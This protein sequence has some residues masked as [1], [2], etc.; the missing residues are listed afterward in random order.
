MLRHLGA[1]YYDSLH[2]R[3]TRVDVA[4]A[5]GTV[6][7]HLT[8]KGHRHPAGSAPRTGHH[9]PHRQPGRWKRRVQDVMTTSVVTIDRATPYKEIALLLAQHQISG[10]PVLT[11]GR[12]VAGIV[13]EA[14][15]L[16]VEDQNARAA[17]RSGRLHMPGARPAHGDL[18]AAEL[19]SS[20]AVTIHPDAPIPS[21]AR[22]MITHHVRRLPV[23]DPD[24]KLMGIVTRR[25]LLSVFLRPDE[26]IAAD[27][28]GLVD[29]VLHA[30][31]VR[32]R[33]V[34]KNGRVFLTGVTSGP[35]EDELVP[36]VIRLIWDVD[37][38]VDVIS[39]LNLPPA[40]GIGPA[41]PAGSAGSARVPVPTSAGR[42][43]DT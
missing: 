23:V 27:A 20:P 1:A 13:S 11:M 6:E 39:R 2:G 3:G 42:A 5:V 30:D 32:I 26:E 16:A 4:R 19:M 35:E 37:G 41:G 17:R 22:M 33:V 28:T 36:I 15:L 29:D 43:G 25:D 9:A 24:G 7:D 21:A 31:P 34:V 40:V 8:E 18:T 14:D 10:A 12:H 38:V